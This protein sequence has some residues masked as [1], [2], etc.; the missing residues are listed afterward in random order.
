MLF[1]YI[2]NLKNIVGLIANNC[3]L[4]SVRWGSLMTGTR[5]PFCD[6][7]ER[8]LRNTEVKS[9]LQRTYNKDIQGCLEIFLKDYTITEW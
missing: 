9:L 8:A 4:K 2:F 3:T 1:F 7:G 6:V 5:D